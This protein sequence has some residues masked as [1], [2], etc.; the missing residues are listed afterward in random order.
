MSGRV[1]VPAARS[2]AKEQRNQP[3]AQRWDTTGF[4]LGWFVAVLVGA[5]GVLVWLGSRAAVEWQRSTRLVSERRADET[6]ILLAAA[7]SKDMKGAQV[8]VIAPVNE[9]NLALDSPYDF[10]DRFER[11][12][13]RFPY[14]ESFFV[15]R[16]GSGASGSTLV[17]HR[18]DRVP[19]W[20]PK[21]RSTSPYPVI[22]VRDPP[23][24]TALVNRVRADAVHRRPF[25]VFQFDLD[26]VPYQVVA[27]L[28][29]RG[30]G[31]GQLLGFVGFTVNVPWVRAHYF[32]ELVDQIARIGAGEE[33][34][35]MALVIRDESGQ[36]VT[37]VG[38]PLDSTHV[39]ERHFALLFFDPDFLASLPNR[40]RFPHW[41]AEV[42]P[43][44]DRAVRAAAVGARRTVWLMSVAVAATIAGLVLTVRAT[45]ASARLAVMKSEFVSTVTHE[46]KTPLAVFRL[47][48]ETLAMRRY[49]SIDAVHDYGRL[50]STEVDRFEHLVDNLLA[51][52]RLNDV[53]RRYDFKAIH[54]I[55]LVE[56]AMDPFQ[57]RL[58]ELSFAVTVDVPHDLPLVRADRPTILQAFRN[59]ID[60]SIKY[61]DGRR[62]LTIRA[63][64]V[65]EGVRFEVEDRGIGIDRDELAHVLKRFVRGTNARA[66]GNGLGLAIAQRIVE[67]HGG[68]LELR[69]RLGEGTVSVVA[70]PGSPL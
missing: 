44:D 65:A 17:F 28:L 27:H 4:A 47:V 62:A 50:L 12:F 23:Q 8:S 24:T 38:S 1:A 51:Y 18:A 5:T 59:L 16:A 52:S 29:Y 48:A 43:G 57:A 22:I 39:R 69:S 35:A 54:P 37:R 45:R 68:T 11:G 41:V 10:A 7:L 21:S 42:R 64:A 31:S 61:S 6:L 36:T 14:P 58:R 49:S 46:L 32:G 67:D 26:G 25:D 56:D 30:T 34:M 15:W 66:G 20:D 13:A 60:N 40:S 2:A 63:A 19:A 55:E 9:E 53:D 3:G 33:A 70:L